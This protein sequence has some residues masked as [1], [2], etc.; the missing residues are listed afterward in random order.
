VHDD[1][2]GGVRERCVCGVA[3]EA[4]Q[5]PKVKTGGERE[6][7]L[8]RAMKGGQRPETTTMAGG[9]YPCGDTGLSTRWSGRACN[10]RGKENRQENKRLT[11]EAVHSQRNRMIS[12]V[13][14]VRHHGRA[15]GDNSTPVVAGPWSLDT[16]SSRNRIQSEERDL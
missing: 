2:L 5:P 11:G 15:A 1:E 3:E 13:S 9:H 7:G 6:G 10:G 14:S 12:R 4:G 8:R 16:K